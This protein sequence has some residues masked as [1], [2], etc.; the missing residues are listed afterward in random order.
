MIILKRVESETIFCVVE[1]L[2]SHLLIRWL[3]GDIIW[4][5]FAVGNVLQKYNKALLG[6]N[7]SL[8][9]WQYQE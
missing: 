8:L 6:E 4:L 7:C 9:Q 5:D 2:F 3:K 1:M